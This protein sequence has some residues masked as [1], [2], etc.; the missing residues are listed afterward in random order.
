MKKLLVST[1]LL[2]S[3][4]AAVSPVIA[5]NDNESR[6]EKSTLAVY[7]DAPYGGRRRGRMSGGFYLSPR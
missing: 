1:A 2:A 5:D 4:L 3:G 6:Y 7:G